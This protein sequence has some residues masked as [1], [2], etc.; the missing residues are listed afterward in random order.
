MT[1]IVLMKTTDYRL[2]STTETWS[3]AV[4]NNDYVCMTADDLT[5]LRDMIDEVLHDS[6]AAKNN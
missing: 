4:G 2:T 1:N 6:P 3:L 5:R